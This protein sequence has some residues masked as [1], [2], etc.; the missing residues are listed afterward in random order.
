MS[1]PRLLPPLVV[2]ILTLAGCASSS[3]SATWIVTSDSRLLCCRTMRYATDEF[4][5][6]ES[7]SIPGNGVVVRLLADTI[8]GTCGRGAAV[9][10]V[11]ANNEDQDVWVPVSNELSA[12]TMTLFPWRL[13]Y[14]SKPGERDLPPIRVA[15]Q[16]EYG[17][18]VERTD[19]HL[20]FERIPAGKEVRLVG[21]IPPRWLCVPPEN[22]TDEA[23]EAELDP[24]V[25]AERTRSIRARHN[26]IAA[27]AF[28]PVAFRYDVAYTRMDY[29][30]TIPSTLQRNDAGDTVTVHVGITDPPAGLLTASQHVSSSNVVVLR[31]T[32]E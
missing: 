24:T 4:T 22:V 2:L 1:K 18:L 23:L 14:S 21:W 17:D 30:D 28:D 26:R 6:P 15:R 7:S 12:D 20:T 25:Y 10:I 8:D 31:I 9:P 29:L 32:G 27:A 16:L 19:A 5:H 13:Y 11:I 3:P